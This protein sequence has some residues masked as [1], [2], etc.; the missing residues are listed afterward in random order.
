MSFCGGW[1]NR[2]NGVVLAYIIA[3]LTGRD[4]KFEHLKPA[5][6]ITNYLSMNKVS[7]HLPHSIHKKVVDSKDVMLINKMNK[8]SFLNS[9]PH[10]NFNDILPPDVPYVYFL[11]NRNYELR[12]KCSEVYRQQ[13]SWMRNLTRGEIKAAIYK[14]LFRLAPP[15]Q[16]KVMN[17]LARHL[18]TSRHKLICAHLRMGK[19]PSNKYDGELQTMDAL[20][21]VWK[22]I[23]RKSI[24]DFHKVFIMSDSDAVMDNAKKQVFRN[25]LV[26][27]EGP[28][29]HIDL[30][31]GDSTEQ[32]CAGF[33]KLLLDQHI[34]M[35]CD[36]LM[37]GNS[38]IS[39]LAA[40]IR[41]TDRELFCHLANGSIVPSTRYDFDFLTPSNGQGTTDENC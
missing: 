19:N 35:N 24:D 20:A 26:L 31:R 28:V 1:D 16:A 8:N 14:R 11:G 32:K 17:I 33:E 37:V 23:Q 39:R 12:I 34:L 6:D 15:M 25:R 18:P 10:T 2:M 27:T 38:G 7:W 40:Y 9:L 22:F 29:V 3:N 41:G 36:V 13:L 21:N 5:C 4:F 30:A